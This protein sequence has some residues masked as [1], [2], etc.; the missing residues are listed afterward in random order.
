M[1]LDCR[2]KKLVKFSPRMI[3]LET[4]SEGDPKKDCVLGF[5]VKKLQEASTMQMKG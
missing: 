3:T 2:M 1:T 4:E 5:I